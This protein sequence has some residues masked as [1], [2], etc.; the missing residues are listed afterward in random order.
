MPQESGLLPIIILLAVCVGL[1]FF[2]LLTVY[3]ISGR[4]GRVERLLAEKKE[5][6][7]AS[8]PISAAESAPGGPFEAFLDE[9]PS[10]RSLS[11]KEQSAAYRKWRQQNGM[12]WSNS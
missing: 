4:L 10:R 9:D 7:P 3:G 11:K 12:N 2:L 5:A 8:E 6:K 1:L